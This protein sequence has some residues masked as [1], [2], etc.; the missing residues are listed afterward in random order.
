M[1]SVK[2]VYLAPLVNVLGLLGET[3]TLPDGSSTAD[4]ISSLCEKHGSKLKEYF[5][6]GAGKLEPKFMITVN[7]EYLS[8]FQGPLPD[9]AEVVFIP[10]IGGG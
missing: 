6:D 4:L 10:A 3:V 8:D 9:K 7:R 2:V 1:I 5:Y